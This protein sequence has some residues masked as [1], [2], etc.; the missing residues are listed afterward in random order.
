MSEQLDSLKRV[1]TNIK[2]EARKM[3]LGLVKQRLEAPGDEPAEGDKHED[4]PAEEKAEKPDAPEPKEAKTD[5]ES[6]EQ[7]KARV[8]KHLGLK[9]RQKAEEAK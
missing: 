9:P 8:L 6:P 5:E 4:S 7:M 3:H 1:L 2:S